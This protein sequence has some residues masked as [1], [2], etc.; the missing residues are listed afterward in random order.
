MPNTFV[1]ADTHWWHNNIIGYCE[2]P[3]ASV[4]DMNETMIDSWNAKVKPEDTVWHLGDFAWGSKAPEIFPRLHGKINFLLGNHDKKDILE[5]L[6]PTYVYHELK[7]NKHYYVLFHYPMRSW[8]R[9]YHGS[10]HFFGHVHGGHDKEN[11]YN[12]MDVGVD[13]AASL[14]LGYAPFALE[15]AVQTI[16]TR[17]G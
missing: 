14:G 4:E 12:S 5:S 9:S 13:S 7:L 15:E 1:T 16:K 10:Y 3:F 17:R 2:R 6:A 8:N 11:L